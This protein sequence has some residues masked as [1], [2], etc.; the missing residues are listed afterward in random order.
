M[1]TIPK[2]NRREKIRLLVVDDHMV[3][4]MGL[5]HAARAQADMEVIAEVES[6][7]EAI[8]AYREHRPHV[9]ILDLRMPGLGGLATIRAI[10]KEFGSA[11]IVVF[12]NYARGEEVFQALKAG[13]AGFV[14]KS[15]NL[16]QLVDAIRRVHAGE[17]YLPP[18]L[19]M[20]MAERTFS[21]LSERE[22]EVLTLI[23]KGQSN[24]EIATTLGVTEGTVKL[25]VTS[26]LSKLE[27]NART[28]ALV[29]A[30]QRGITDIEPK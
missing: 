4:R 18:E 13:A 17:R 10:R 8:E 2:T 1:T 14:V 29:V 23:A 26:I 30:V 20:R 11:R 25:H 7:E 24:K 15:M 5:V 22:T 12:S 27:V 6:G 19:A 9:A 16:S 21:P 3:M 28:E